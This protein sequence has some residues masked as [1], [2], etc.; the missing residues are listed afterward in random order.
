M[1]T[2]ADRVIEVD[3]EI[4]VA[5][6]PGTRHKTFRVLAVRPEAGE[7]DAFDG[8]KRRTFPL[9]RC[10]VVGAF[11]EIGEER[12]L[13]SAA[14]PGELLLVPTEA[15]AFAP[16]N[17]RRD[18]GD[19]SEL[20]DSIRAVGIV[21]PLVAEASGE[22]TYTL[23]AGA[24]RLAAA[25]EVGLSHVPVVVAAFADDRGRLE[26]ML[27]ENL[28]RADLS[29]IEEAHAY[30]RLLEAAGYTQREL[31]ERVGRSQGH[32]SKRLALLELPEPA[33][34]AIDSG[35]ITV[36]L[37]LDLAK[38]ATDPVA[39]KETAKAFERAKEPGER[40]RD[41]ELQRIVGDAE[42]RA[43]RE[44][45]HQKLKD[46]GIRVLKRVPKGA[47]ELNSW[48]ELAHV[49]RK[50]HA[51]EPCHVVVTEHG[52]DQV[53]CTT[54]SNHPK[55]KGGSAKKGQV[56][57]VA[58][59]DP[60]AVALGEAAEARVAFLETL[61]AQRRAPKDL[62]DLVFRCVATN[63]DEFWPDPEIFERILGVE[64]GER[65]WRD[66]WLQEH[67]DRLDRMA[68]AAVCSWYESTLDYGYGGWAKDPAVARFFAWLELNGYQVAEV[69]RT[70]L[71][72]TEP[73]TA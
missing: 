15:L 70:E 10:S 58:A 56:A 13:V 9:E 25:R 3:D 37:G 68:G 30:R 2:T 19:L 47:V 36:E 54:P 20:A 43:Q 1:S 34:Q 64:H 46:K 61:F 11:L 7:V 31:A 49:D 51:K 29:V 73:D 22:G 26:T 48:G 41:W 33:L 16:D 35:G 67:P 40:I 12:E 62:E 44:A 65:D 23:V 39:A 8:D 50:A 21:E 4:E 38:V 66:R 55:P 60:R 24:R 52:Y 59:P 72:A 27:V 69:E 28:Q 6:W 57:K 5:D 63:T 17:P 14:I 42:R 45:Q 71:G 18:L 53:Y 32:V